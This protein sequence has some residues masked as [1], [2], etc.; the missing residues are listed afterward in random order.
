MLLR[1]VLSIFLLTTIATAH[2]QTA[3]PINVQGR[4]TVDGLVFNGTGKFKFALVNAAGNVLY[5]THDGTRNAAPY[6]PTGSVDINV[7]RGLYSVLIGD[8]TIPGMTNPINPDI[9]TNNDVRLRIWFN[10]NT[11]DFQQL[12]PDQRMAA[13]GYAFVAER[14]DQA[15]VLTGNVSI[16]QVPSI[17]ITNNAT[18][19]SLTGTFSGGPFTGDGSGLTG[20][21][22]STPFQVVDAATN[23]AVPNTGYML[24][25]LNERA[26]LLPDTASMQ[27][28]DIVRIAGPGSWK[29]TQRAG[30]SVSATH[31]RGG[32]GAKWVAREAQR[33]WNAIASST[34]GLN[35]VAFDRTRLVYL[36][37][38]GGLNWEVPPVSPQK[39]WS[40]AASSADGQRL[41]AGTTSD[42]LFISSDFGRGWSQRIGPGQRAW[43]AV[44][45]SYDGS[46]MVAVASANSP[47][48]V[49]IDGGDNF[50]QRAAAATANW[51]GV[52]M[53]ADGT[54][55]FAASGAALLISTNKG[56]NF[57]SFNVAA[58]NVGK[59]ACS[60]DGQRLTVLHSA[61]ASGNY[62]YTSADR[63]ATWIR[64]DGAGSRA[65][66][67]L[68]CSA[69]G[70][71]IAATSPAGISIS[72]DGG[73]AWAVRASA[74]TW[75]AVTC[76]SDG[77][78]FAATSSVNNIYTSDAAALRTTTVG[79]AGYLAGGEYSAVELQHA[80]NGRFFPLS[81][82]G[83]IFAY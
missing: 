48:Y 52:A 44:A 75:T 72:V 24:T 4:V 79:T 63:G 1:M 14:A 8:T 83:Q 77:L 53:T 2:A 43:N 12:L 50:V 31:F 78:K 3:L 17:L 59:I 45:C 36:S 42:Y 34:N 71:I 65:W 35:L 54:N 30:Q 47:L 61:G 68:A 23:N 80:G 9:F 11:H 25:N 20:I 76:S 37:T 40:V 6:Q 46:N 51:G 81:S 16:Q 39:N 55:I 69:D 5:W 18:S 26:V 49:S 58:G 74:L 7:V 19:I 38:N 62:I 41:I 21:R 66:T 64:R 57:G 82:S 32:V 56:T 22:G 60:A 67:S 73:G 27:V 70:S 10:D 29:V 15:A 28:G 13:V 33:D